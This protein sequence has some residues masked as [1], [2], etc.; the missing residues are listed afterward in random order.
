MKYVILATKVL[1]KLTKN[2]KIILFV[3][4]LY[5]TV[6]VRSRGDDYD[7]I[8]MLSVQVNDKAMFTL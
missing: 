5:C 6:I 2:D 8:L 1:Q 3:T 4:L 7:Q